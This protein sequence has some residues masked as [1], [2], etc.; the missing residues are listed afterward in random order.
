MD[1]HPGLLGDVGVDQVEELDELLLAVPAVA[2]ADDLPGGP[3]QGR[4]QR[5]RAVAGIVVGVPF[6]LA[7]LQRQ[8]R[9]GAVQRLDLGFLVHAQDEGTLRRAQVQ[10]DP[11][12][13]LFHEP[14][15]GGQFE[16]VGPMRLQPER[17]LDAHDGGLGQAGDLG[18][19]PRAPVGGGL[20]FAFQGAR[21][22]A[23]GRPRIMHATKTTLA[24]SL[25]QRTP[26]P[27]SSSAFTFRKSPHIGVA[28]AIGSPRPRPLG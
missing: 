22:L 19:A 7:R 4:E 9:L 2:L 8:Q 3:V 23:L 11:V 21:D 14:G 13:D 27:T 16:G 1:R 5:S 28:R 24:V 25:A 6:R 17:T 20:G 12:A 26:H 15:V 10:A 18:R